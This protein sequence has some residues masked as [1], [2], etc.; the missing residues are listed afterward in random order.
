ME[1]L[2]EYFTI[3]VESVWIADPQRQEVSVYHSLSEVQRFTTDDT[4]SGEPVLTGFEA[5]VAEVFEVAFEE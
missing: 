5:S 1:K 3:G 2:E 4:L